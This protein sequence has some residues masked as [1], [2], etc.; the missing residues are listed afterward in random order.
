MQNNYAECLAF[1]ITYGLCILFA[2][3]WIINDI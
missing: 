2:I 3:V 1:T